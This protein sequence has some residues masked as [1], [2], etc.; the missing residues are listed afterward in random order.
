MPF[1]TAESYI[2]E[3]VPYLE[4]RS[5]AALLSTLTVSLVYLTLWESGHGVPACLTAA[6]LMLFDTAQI[7]QTRLIY[8][9]AP[10]VFELAAT[11]YCYTRFCKLKRQAFSSQW[12]TWLFLTGLALSCGISTKYVGVFGYATLGLAVAVDIWELFDIRCARAVDVSILSKHVAAR[13]LMLIVIPFAFYLLWFYIHFAILNKTGSGNGFMSAEFVR[14]LVNNVTLAQPTGRGSFFQ[15][16][17]E[18]QKAMFEQTGNANIRAPHPYESSPWE[19]PLALGGVNFWESGE[20]DRQ[21]IYQQ[22]N[23]PGWWICSSSIVVLAVIL[24]ID[25]LLQA[26]GISTIQERARRRLFRSS[27]FYALAWVMHYV[28]FWFMDRQLMLHNYL[29]AHMA[30][31]LVTGSLVELLEPLRDPHVVDKR[32]S[33]VQST[34]RGK[35][36]ARAALKMQTIQATQATPAVFENENA[37]V[38]CGIVVCLS[39]VFWLFWLPLTYGQPGLTYQDAQR[40]EILGIGLQFAYDSHRYPRYS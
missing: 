12:W 37:W 25:Q 38:A 5:V 11:L 2:T 18:L 24:L 40:R 28:P 4:L 13:L 22:G 35:P 36:S 30:S 33:K 15:K 23:V 34:S 7:S 3:D 14:S 27:C 10:L 9:D 26:R 21:Q 31:T 29:P 1:A 16:Y 19:W 32:P 6:G 8:L 17:M 39:F 20:Q